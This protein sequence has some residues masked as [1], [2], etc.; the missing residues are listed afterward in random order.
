M[1]KPTPVTV[2]AFTVTS[3]LPIDV[4]VTDLVA[5]EFTAT[6]PKL[7]LVA[8]TVNCGFG[9]TA[10][11]PL[12]A[13]AAVLPLDELLL[14]II[15]PLAEPVTVGLNCICSVSDWFGFNVVGKP[16]LTS[17]NPEPLI[18]AE[19]TVTGAVPVDVS[20][21]VCVV[22][23]FT[24]T[25]PK[26]KLPTLNVSCGLG[27]AILVPLSAT[28]AVLPV[29]ELLLIANW[30]LVAPVAVGLNCICSVSDWSGFNVAG[31]LPT[32]ENPEPLIAAEFTV[33]GAAPV[34]V[35]VSA[36]V[37]DVFT[38]TLPKLKLP[39]LNVSCGLGAAILVPL[40]ATIAVLPLDELLL[41][42]ICPLAASVAV[43]LN[44]ICSVSDW[45]G[46]NVAGKLPPASENPEPLIAAALTVTGAVP[47]D[48]SVS[49]CVVD[50]FT[51]T[52]PKLKLPAL[53]VSWGSC[54]TT[55]LPLSNTVAVLFVAESL[56]T[57]N[58]PF[59]APVAVGLNCTCSVS[60]WFGFN[61]AGK[62]PLTSENPEP[63]IV[64]EFTV[65]GDVPAD[66]SVNACIVDE[67]TVTLPKS[68]L[69]ALTDICAVNCAKFL[70]RP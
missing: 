9:T 49:V 37:V 21:T 31:K 20:V 30:P 38:V 25:L 44:C 43:G 8:P 6:L 64:A 69:L 63:L 2:A 27:A 70:P 40:S 11:V 51:V 29:A 46:F 61:V 42:I 12:R 59:V 19:F 24:I 14:I 13:T 47:V 17:E 35:S 34:D 22:D 41:I 26:L 58:W 33:T 15:C 68:S 60:D 54:V 28:I 16:P 4:S 65:T 18:V 67:P 5:A 39:T 66:V 1:V 32:S 62:L 56:L 57:V 50:V 36:C 48:V 3:E 52:L 7:R 45:F 10:P 23:V 55:P 53:N